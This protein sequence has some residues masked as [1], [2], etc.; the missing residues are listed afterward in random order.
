[1]RPLH[2]TISA[3]GPYAEKIEIDLSRLGRSGLYLITGD[4]GAGK[5]TI[6]DAITYALYGGPSGTN[7]ETKSFRSK[8]A[9][10]TTPTFIRLVFEYKD[11][12]YTVTRSPEY[13]RPSKRDPN[14]LTK[15]NA[16]VEL[17]LP[18]NRIVTKDS[19]VKKAV[20][21]I[22]GIS[23]EQFSQIAMIAQGDFLK[24][25]LASTED[26]TKIFRKLFKT[27]FFDKLQERLKTQTAELKLECDNLSRDFDREV[28]RILCDD[29]DSLAVEVYRA[30]DKK[31]T[32][33]ETVFLVKQLIENDD[34][35]E[36]TLSKEKDEIEQ[37]ITEIT[38]KLTKAAETERQRKELQSSK[39]QLEKSIE[40]LKK[41]EEEH[42]SANSHK[43]EIDELVK[44]VTTLESKL[45]DYD[46]YEKSVTAIKN[47]SDK[48]K[49]I[50]E[51][52]IRGRK[53][54]E[55]IGILIE[56]SEQELN[57]IKDAAEV[58]IKLDAEKDNLDTYL[59]KLDNI[60]S[61]INYF[62]KAQRDFE[63]AKENYLN[64]AKNAESQRDNYNAKHRLFLN[65]QAG[66]LAEEL[67]DGQPC[68]VCGSVHHPHKAE[69]SAN[70]PSKE[71]L[72]KIKLEAEKAE[73][74]AE[75]KSSDASEFN[76]KLKE[77]QGQLYLL[78]QE[79]FSETHE[80]DK[81]IKLVRE[82]SAE[83]QQ[84]EEK[85]V[86]DIESAEK[87]VHRKEQL[88]REIPEY[89]REEN[90][91]SKHLSSLQNEIV[92]L[93]TKLSEQKKFSESLREK[94]E[95]GTRAEAERKIKEM[96]S[97][98]IAFENAIEITAKMRDE[99]KSRADNSRGKVES[100][101]RQLESAPNI[102]VNSEK[103]SQNQQNYLKENI[104]N[105]LRDVAHRKKTNTE[106]LNFIEPNSK[107]LAQTEKRWQM[108][109][110]LSSVANGQKG[111]NINKKEKTEKIKLETF[112]QMNYFDKILLQANRRFLV[113]SNNQYELKRHQTADNEK[114]KI[115]QQVQT[116]LDLDVIDHYN[117][118]VR[119]VKTLSGGESF[120]ASLSLALGLSDE[121][122]ASAGGI[123]LNTMFVDEGFGSL[124]EESLRQAFK[125]LNDL[126]QNNR[127]VGIISHVSELKGK[128]DK[129]IV[130][131]KDRSSGS[132]V[133]II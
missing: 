114:E 112:V 34:N 46:N 110:E 73:K 64:A 62:V 107:K 66:I 90:K 63:R 23:K 100:L 84:A 50:R 55:D 58:K 111:A 106:V 59:K 125:A 15:E 47:I 51:R 86:A 68:P 31:T 117:G 97:K 6:F 132:R 2:L 67:S 53:K 82:I 101:I 85:L 88:E 130:V 49:L 9:K 69:K 10:D 65:E 25:L 7:R 87:K 40:L 45:H 22:V 12:T 41:A 37:R 48:L 60:K 16:S 13:M 30:K 24:L 78:E 33:E 28:Q 109:S 119:S 92:A 98:I 38:E 102:D 19:E 57:I 120:K 79:M 123:Q 75:E 54:T 29:T 113:M 39:E 126:T 94:L 121:I 115:N 56:R 1:M 118:T 36:R 127:L 61:S 74:Q 104:E 4:T 77:R 128:I 83:K 103:E 14:K 96:K 71:E 44:A 26:R 42:M 99:I 8:Y 11:K 133:D 27:E 17:V 80:T 81:L 70:A 108:V 105:K 116:G 3:F 43:S 35:R 20:E 122:Q 32:A 93:E 95:C 124:D 131:T 129:Q 89:R 52:E 72:E 76:A 21:D 91:Y 5:T 18:D